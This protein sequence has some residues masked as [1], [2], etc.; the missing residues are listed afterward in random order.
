MDGICDAVVPRWF[1]PG[2]PTAQPARYQATVRTFRATDPAGYIGC[3]QALAL[4]DLRDQVASIGIP[5]LIV[6]GELDAS[7]PPEQQRWLHTQIAGSELTI[8]ERAA[9]LSNLDR[10][11]DFTTRLR[12]FVA[13]AH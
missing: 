6:G 8:F 3:C 4:A 9:H 5:T 1:A 7:T 13:R 12:R 10:P 11:E 2:F